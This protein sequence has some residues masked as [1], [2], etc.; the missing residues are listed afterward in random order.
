[1]SGSHFALCVC[2][3]ALALLEL[4][5][6]AQPARPVQCRELRAEQVYFEVNVCD[7]N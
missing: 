6:D 5:V 4:F 2:I 7:V 1:M 3:S